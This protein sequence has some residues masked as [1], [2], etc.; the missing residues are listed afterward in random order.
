M[1]V[2]SGIAAAGGAIAS[3]IGAAASGI[4][5]GAAA[6]GA[7]GLGGLL[8]SVAPAALS[9]GSTYLQSRSARGATQDALAAQLA[10]S[11]QQAAVVRQN[12]LDTMT[13]LGPR[14]RAGDTALGQMMFELGLSDSPDIPDEWRQSPLV[15]QQPAGR[16]PGSAY[17]ERYG[18]LERAYMGLS[19]RDQNYIAQQGY[20]QNGDGRIDQNEYGLFHYATH[21]RSEGRQSPERN[22]QR[23]N[24]IDRQT[25]RQQAPVAAQGAG[26]GRFD[27][28]RETPGYQFALQEGIRAQDASAASRGMLL[29]GRQL[30]ALQERGMGLADQTYSQYWNRLAGVAGVGG[31]ATG[32]AIQTGGQTAGA[33]S[34]IFGGAGDARAS[35]YLTQ[36][37]LDAQ[38]IGQMG[39]IAGNI[40]GKYL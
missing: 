17:V 24:R 40:L 22:L 30:K 33:L 7:G 26:E 25:A 39:G 11:D 1:P 31:A 4:G 19:S 28:F 10:A 27:R 15:S 2:L 9:L 32:Q 12:F 34:N 13:M 35:S 14:I 21:G 37:A 38:M 36:G 6:A 3:G 23:L 8:S 18:D 20:D 5:A 16:T 29:S